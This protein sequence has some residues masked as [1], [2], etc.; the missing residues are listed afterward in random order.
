MKPEM[1]SGIIVRFEGKERWSKCRQFRKLNY[2]S[3][4]DVRTDF[5]ICFRDPKTKRQHCKGQLS[6]V[7]Y[8]PI[9]VPGIEM[10]G[11]GL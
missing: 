7:G 6:D 11:P 5:S 10:K 4:K 1:K 2:M 3:K 8:A 9:R